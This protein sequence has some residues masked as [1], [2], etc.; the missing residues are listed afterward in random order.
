MLQKVYERLYASSK[1]YICIMEYYNPTPIPISYRGHEGYLF[2]RDFAGEMMDL[3]PPLKLID[4]GFIY[5]RDNN[6]RQD[7]ETWFLLSK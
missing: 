4:Y 5:H 7:D 1:K 3:Y 2:K 6:F